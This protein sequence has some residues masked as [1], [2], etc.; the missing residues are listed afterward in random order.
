M[1]SG[2]LSLRLQ[3]AMSRKRALT[4]EEA[5]Q[6]REMYQK[7]YRISQDHL[8][9]IFKVSQSTIRNAIDRKGA[10]EEEEE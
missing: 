9:A 6:V 1:C 5:K 3:E 10:Y 4:P 2:N 8:A 7:N